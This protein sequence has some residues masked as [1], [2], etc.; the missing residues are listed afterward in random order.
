M[1]I[2][3]VEV[4]LG[5][6]VSSVEIT[7]KII[8]IVTTEYVEALTKLTLVMRVTVYITNAR[9]IP[10]AV[11][12]SRKA[13]RLCT[14]SGTLLGYRVPSKGNRSAVY[15]RFTDIIEKITSFLS[16]IPPAT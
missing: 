15:P 13:S 10:Q 9:I 6:P 5:S 3:S 16:I 8:H 14:V 11:S 1:M 4:A 2:L 12:V 7:Q